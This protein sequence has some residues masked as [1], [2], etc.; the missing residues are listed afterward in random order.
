MSKIAFIIPV[1]NRLKYTKECLD[2][3]EQHKDTQFF[4]KNEISIIVSDDSSTDGTEEWIHSNHPN[5]IV[6]KGTGSLW[7]SGSL[8]LGIKYAF[9]KLD[10][11]FIM[12]WE[13]DIYPVDEYFN[14]LQL[15]LE[16][17]DGKTLICSKLNYRVRPDIIFGLG[18]TFDPRTGF[19]NLIGQQEPDGP[20][21]NK[22]IEADWFLGQ[23]VLIHRDII[24]KVGYFDEINFPQ[25]HA[26]IDYGLRAKKAGYHNMVYP[27]LKL[28]NDTSTTGMS[29]LKDKTLKQFIESLYSIK[30]NTNIKKDIRFN[31]IHATNYRAYF[32]LVRKYFMYTA[33]FIK[34]KVLGWVGIKRKDEE[35]Y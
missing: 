27:N 17:W 4:K 25:Y 20:Q 13:N 1:F 6:L 12:V 24:E 35:L 5:V 19:R 32:F 10:C 11:D 26:D 15:I 18:G 31:R 29:H 7:Y 16:K 34:W 21:Y 30:S 22:I 23:G 2:I 28:L 33:S 3:L 9:E 8:N 14:N